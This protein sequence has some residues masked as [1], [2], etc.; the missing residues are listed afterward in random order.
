MVTSDMLECTAFEEVL[1]GGDAQTVANA[2]DTALALHQN[3][4]F[5]KRLRAL[6]NANSWDVRAETYIKSIENLKNR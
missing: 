6:A 1:A 4:D 5:R 3:P 2:I